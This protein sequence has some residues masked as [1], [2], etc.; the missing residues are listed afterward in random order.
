MKNEFKELSQEIRQTLENL[1]SPIFLFASQLKEHCWHKAK[2]YFSEMN[3]NSLGYHNPKKKYV[4][5]KIRID[6]IDVVIVNE[7]TKKEERIL[8]DSYDFIVPPSFIGELNK[9][10]IVTLE[11]RVL[12][13]KKISQRRFK[14]EEVNI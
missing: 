8:E 5:F 9:C 13:F 10:G 6:V 1:E 2:F 4:G 14:F 11:D 7:E 3:K 12:S